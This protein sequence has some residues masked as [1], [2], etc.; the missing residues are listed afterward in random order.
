MSS[1]S[2]PYDG[3]EDFTLHKAKQAFLTHLEEVDTSD[4]LANTLVL[5]FQLEPDVEAE[6]NRFVTDHGCS[7]DSRVL[8]REE[9]DKI[10]KRRKTCAQYTWFQV[11]PEAQEDYLKTKKK[12]S[13]APSKRPAP[14]KAAAA[15]STPTK[16]PSKPK[17][18][19]TKTKKVSPPVDEMAE[20]EAEGSSTADDTLSIPR[21]QFKSIVARLSDAL[22]LIPTDAPGIECRDA[23]LAVGH[24]MRGLMLKRPHDSEE[25]EGATPKKAKRPRVSRA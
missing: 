24:E 18:P 9:Q 25:T 14:K 8:T 10:D 11:T 21:A 1:P 2:R 7:M 20:V 23:L 13:V 12:G 19:K 22:L 16:S 15:R 3:E 17:T 5:K 6:L 4:G